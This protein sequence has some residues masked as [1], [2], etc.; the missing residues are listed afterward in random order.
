MFLINF[1]IILYFIILFYIFFFFFKYI[2][3]YNLLIILFNIIYVIC[4]FRAADITVDIL[5]VCLCRKLVRKEFVNRLLELEYGEIDGED[6]VGL[7]AENILDD[8]SRPIIEHLVST[9]TTSF[10]H[11]ESRIETILKV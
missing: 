10:L 4:N 9:A 5:R 7:T 6:S 3:I 11:Q 8:P 1:Y 2:Y